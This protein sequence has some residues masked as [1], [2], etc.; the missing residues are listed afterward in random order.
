MMA[1]VIDV[2]ENATVKD[3]ADTFLW[4]VWKVHG[5]LTENIWDMDANH[6]A[7]C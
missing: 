5:V 1:Y 7:K 3:L 6:C 4:E 2:C